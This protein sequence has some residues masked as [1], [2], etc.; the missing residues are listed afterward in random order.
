MRKEVLASC[1]YYWLLFSLLSL[2]AVK[3]LIKCPKLLMH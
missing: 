1:I 3:D 2:E